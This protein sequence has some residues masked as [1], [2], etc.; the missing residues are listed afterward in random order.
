MVNHHIRAW[1]KHRGLTIDRLAEMMEREPGVQLITSV[2][3]GRIERGLQPYSQANLEAIAEA[4]DVTPAML[5]EQDP[6]QTGE[7]T[8][9]ARLVS[10][11]DD[12]TRSTILAMVRAAIRH[13][14]SDTE[15]TN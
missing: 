4:L 13:A 11:A 6:N 7:V 1:R 5:L 3:L 8:D 2:S 12:T 9:L 10:K 15:R 14:T